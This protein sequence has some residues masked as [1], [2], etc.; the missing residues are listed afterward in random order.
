MASKPLPQKGRSPYPVFPIVV[1]MLGTKPIMNGM[2][3]P[4][5]ERDVYLHYST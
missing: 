4:L 1:G 2:I 5:E 3:T